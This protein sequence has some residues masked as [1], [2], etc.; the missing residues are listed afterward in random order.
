MHVED[1]IRVQRE[2]GYRYEAA[3]D[4]VE[5]YQ[6]ICPP[7]RRALLAL[8]QG[9]LWHGQRGGIVLD[10]PTGSAGS[11]STVTAGFDGALCAAAF[12][13]LRRSRRFWLLDLDMT[14]FLVMEVGRQ[15]ARS[16][17]CVS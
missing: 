7:C 16:A 4:P 13:L 17:V 5:H 11:V 3:H 1:L 15:P 12:A 10:S 14:W 9:Q 8:A 6:W 2:L